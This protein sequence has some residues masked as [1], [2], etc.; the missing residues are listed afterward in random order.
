MPT[1]LFVLL[2]LLQA[3]PFPGPGGAASG[4]SS[5]GSCAF[6]QGERNF[7]GTQPSISQA[8]D[9]STTAGNLIVS[10][11]GA[12]GSNNLNTISDS[13]SNT[14][15]NTIYRGNPEGSMTDTVAYAT[16]ST[17]ANTLSCAPTSGT[18]APDLVLLEFSGFSG[19]PTLDQHPTAGVC[20]PCGTT[21]TT[22]SITISQTEVVVST[23]YD[24]HSSHTFSVPTG[25]TICPKCSTQN[26][27]SGE[28]SAVAYQILTAG[29]Y[30]LIWTNNG[31]ASTSGT[32]YTI[33]SFK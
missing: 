28:S 19:L 18:F 4:G 29:T 5:C 7:L 23:I 33:A 10:Q 32:V 25:W 2:L 12:F 16:A 26:T 22:P 27:A 30:S 17:G 1:F 8:F 15:S 14:Y 11:C 3:L 9:S 21:M 6:V 20:A 13:Q 24:V 31:A